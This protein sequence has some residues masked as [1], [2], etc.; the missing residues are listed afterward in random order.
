MVQSITR[1]LAGHLTTPT[2][3]TCSPRKAAEAVNSCR[4]TNSERQHR[5]QAKIQADTVATL[6]QDDRPD[7]KLADELHTTV[8][9][10]ENLQAVTD[11]VNSDIANLDDYFRPLKR[12]LLLGAALR[13][14]SLC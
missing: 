5:K 13:R 4:S 6:R 11:E 2:F 12:L 1:P 3:R 14:H 7:P 10:L 8:L 9:T